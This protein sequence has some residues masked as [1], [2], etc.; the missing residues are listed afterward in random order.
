MVAA[1]SPFTPEH[2][3]W[4]ASTD[5]P[6]AAAEEVVQDI[7]LAVIEGIDR[8]EARSSLKIWL[9]SILMN[10]MRNL[11]PPRPSQR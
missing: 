5:L 6:R 11:R 7:W 4:L 2:L 10:R 3:L 1:R 8:F 9:F